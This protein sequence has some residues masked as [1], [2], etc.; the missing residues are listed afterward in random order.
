LL[1]ETLAWACLPTL[2]L[3]SI[4]RRL[5]RLLLLLHQELLLHVETLQVALG[6]GTS[7]LL[8]LRR[9]IQRLILYRLAVEVLVLLTA[10][11][12]VTWARIVDSFGTRA[13][14]ALPHVIIAVVVSELI[15][16]DER[17]LALDLQWILL[18]L[19]RLARM[20]RLLRGVESFKIHIWHFD[21]WFLQ[22]LLLR[23]LGWVLLE[24]DVGD[25]LI[26]WDYNTARSHLNA[27]FFLRRDI[28]I[29]KHFKLW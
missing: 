16:L 23:W 1:V 11:H 18:K 9:L 7:R 3:S 6:R 10:E 2:G 12:I 27:P 21:C 26:G 22:R 8:E 17:H 19:L 5:R 29:I 28:L 25:L 24:V 14:A 20:R 15:V 13:L 4:L